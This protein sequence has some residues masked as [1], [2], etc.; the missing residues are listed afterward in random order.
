MCTRLTRVASLV[1]LVACTSCA[2]DRSV[3]TTDIGPIY[4]ALL[5]H[6]KPEH[7]PRNA[8]LDPYFM[9]DSGTYERSGMLPREVVQ[10]FLDEGL[11]SE[12]CTALPQCVTQ[13]AVVW[14]AF[15]RPVLV[16]QDTVTVFMGSGTL[17]PQ[18]DSSSGPP[19]ILVSTE[20]CRV[21]YVQGRWHSAG[22]KL[23]T[24]S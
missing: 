14:F 11:V 21:V 1:G 7:P 22:C 8:A 23:L 13:A 16:G 6:D 12:V 19:I 15:S 4:A 18:T 5:N 20:Q 24:I 9:S 2:S 17:R 10:Y 3:R